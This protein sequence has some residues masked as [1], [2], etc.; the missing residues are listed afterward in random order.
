MKKSFITGVLATTMSISCFQ[1]VSAFAETSKTEVKQTS[2]QHVMVRNT[3]SNSIRTLGAQTP[4][5]QAYGLVILQQPNVK[6]DAMSSLTNH[7]QFAKNN[8]REW[9][10]QYNPKLM[11]LNQEMMRFSTR[12]NS[13][14]SK[15][16]DL[17]GEANT[18]EEAKT[19]FVSAFN[20]FQGQVEMIQYDMEQIL[21]E[22]N[23]YETL[24]IQDSE[25]FSE[26]AGV[27]LQSLQGTNGDVTQLRADIKRIQ[28][29]IQNELT[30]ILNR[31]KEIINGSINIGKQVF[32]ITTN[33]AQSKTID[34]VSISSLS[35]EL[36]NVSDSQT[37]EAAYRIQQK[38]QELLPLIQKLSQ[39]QIQA[40]QITLI[41]DQVDGFTELIKRQITT[42]EYLL[43]DW[44]ALNGTMVQ[45]QTN[46]ET[47]ES[48]DSHTLQTQLTQFKKLSDEMNK[49]TSQY[50]D[51]ITNVRVK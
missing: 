6:I 19:N 22:L 33:G 48:I 37:K 10:D 21:L 4:L 12:F 39:T 31:P 27:A 3:L 18:N 34:F 47:N 42:L 15:L 14:Y 41:E 40:T 11:D 17:A 23:R 1:P 35:D 28:E 32:T 25:N 46:L 20:R 7:Q 43:E 44:K 51:F 26:R 50:E 29:E 16:H 30:N 9:M 36:I 8:V 2:T 24:L 38:Q 13:Y 49:Q 45:I 5:I